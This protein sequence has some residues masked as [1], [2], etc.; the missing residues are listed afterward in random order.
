MASRALDVI[1]FC[2]YVPLVV[3]RGARAILEVAEPLCGLMDSLGAAQ[4][5]ATGSRLPTFDLHCPLMSLPLAFGTRLD[6]IP[7]AVPYLVPP[8]DAATTWDARLGPRTRPRIG[9]AWAGN[10]RQEND[11]N[12]SASLAALLPLLDMDA[13]F[14]SLQ[15]DL[16]AGDDRVLKAREDIVPAGSTLADFADAAALVSRMDVVVSVDTSIAHLA[17]ALGK[18]VL[19]LLCFTPDWRWL[20]AGDTCPWYPTARLFRQ[21][22]PQDW[23]EPVAQVAAALRTMVTRGAGP[24]CGEGL[25]PGAPDE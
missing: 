24:E 3:A 2:R 1:Q 10:P 20:L 5:V 4:I 25:V 21:V 9:V 11:R 19:V 17:G 6:T 18:P 23:D 7:A 16:R 14:V 8:A 22:R 12:R 15:K 13:T